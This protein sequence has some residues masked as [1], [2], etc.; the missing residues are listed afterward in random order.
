P[1]IAFYSI[2]GKLVR[3]GTLVNAYTS[4]TGADG[5]WALGGSAAMPTDAGLDTALL[6][7]TASSGTNA[8]ASA[9]SFGAVWLTP[10]L[11]LGAGLKD[12]WEISYANVVVDM[13]KQGRGF[14]GVGNRTARGFNVIGNR[15][16]LPAVDANGWPTGDFEVTLQKSVPNTGHV[17]NGTYK[18]SF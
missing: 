6:G 16:A 1:D 15:N 3:D 9:A 10:T 2:Y 17:Y 7:L 4:P 11:A 12:V 14:N 18:L 5:S 13:V 8:T